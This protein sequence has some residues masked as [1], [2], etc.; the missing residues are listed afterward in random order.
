MQRGRTREVQPRWIEQLRSGQQRRIPH[1]TAD[2]QFS[3]TYHFSIG[4]M[5]RVAPAWLLTAG[6]ADDTSPVSESNRTVVL[7]LDRQ[8]RYAASVQYDLSTA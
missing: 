7:P 8:I 4:A 6:F 1:T 5:Y 3:N 2:L